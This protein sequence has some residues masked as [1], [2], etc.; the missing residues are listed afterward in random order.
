MLGHILISIM[1]AGW[2]AGPGESISLFNGED[3]TGWKADVPAADKGG[4]PP[5]FIVRDGVLVS[6]GKPGGHLVT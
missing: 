3:L 6:M 5:S 4:V 2:L 1:V